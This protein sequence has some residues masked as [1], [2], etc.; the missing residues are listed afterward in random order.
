MKSSSMRQDGGLADIQ[1]RA[2]GRTVVVSALGLTQILAWGSSYYLL[3]V[4]AAPI[5]AETGWPLPWVIGGLTIAQ[6]VSGIAAPFA[7]RSIQARGGR[8]ALVASSLLLAAGLAGMAVAPSLPM[9]LAAWLL[10]GAGMGCGLYDAAFAALGR[11]YGLSARGAI[12]TLTLFG[13]LAS[14]VCWPLSAFLLAKLGWRETCLVYA[15]TQLSFSLP[16]H[17]LTIPTPPPLERLAGTNNASSP[18]PLQPGGQ[19]TAFILLAVLGMLAGIVSGIVSVHLLTILQLRGIEL[20]TAVALG[21]LIG[22]SQVGSRVIE[23]A[24]G[25]HYHPVWTMLAA[26]TL[27]AIGCALLAPTSSVTALALILYGAGNGIFSIARGAVPLVL[28]ETSRY[29]V[30]M[31]RL[32]TPSMLAQAAAPLLGALILLQAGA[33]TLLAALIVI[34]AI[35]IA[36][37]L[38]LWR[39]WWKTRGMRMPV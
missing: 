22:P 28:F 39:L 8:P 10:M 19:R 18:P 5:V 20:A 24:F 36:V 21:A 31:G 29:A 38:A 2:A 26:V 1:P 12:T 25:R 7:G 35:N 37:G 34:A 27:I 9:F 32:A 11:L 4:L 16:L 13:G 30:V 15:A 3:T 33:A 17:V 6:F 14:T 23:M